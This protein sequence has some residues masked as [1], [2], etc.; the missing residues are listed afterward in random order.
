MLSRV[1]VGSVMLAVVCIILATAASAAAD[2]GADVEKVL[3]EIRQDQ[4]VPPLDYLARA[5]SINTG[6]TYYRGNYRGIDITVETHPNSD[7]AASILLQIP[8][9][10]RTGEIL[11][12]VKRV[13][14]SP[15][16]G[17]PKESRYGWQWSNYR[18]ASV[19]YARGAKPGEGLTIISLYYQ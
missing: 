9:G 18:S 11:P 10:D 17:K 5:Q 2:M 4:P 15:R 13:I 8:G 14:G 12:S 19:H 6:C 3:R 16:Y 7:R 1:G